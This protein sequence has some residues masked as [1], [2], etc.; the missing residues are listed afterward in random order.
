MSSISVLKVTESK[1]NALA[2]HCVK[3]AIFYANM[4]IYIYI[5]AKKNH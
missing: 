1:E 3:Y 2:S 5:K 4:H